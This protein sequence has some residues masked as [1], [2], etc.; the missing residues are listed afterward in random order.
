M[1]EYN[2]RNAEDHEKASYR[3]YLIEEKG[4]TY[5][6][7]HSAAETAEIGILEGYRSS[8]PSNVGKILIAFHLQVTLCEVYKYREEGNLQKIQQHQ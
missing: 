5:K 1:N 3:T 7:A 4:Y 2:F 6:E 8:T